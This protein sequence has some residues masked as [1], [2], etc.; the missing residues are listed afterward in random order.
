MYV[1]CK[2]M[3][4]REARISTTSPRAMVWRA[5]ALHG[6]CLGSNRCHRERAMCAELL[7]RS[8]MRRV[9]S[10]SFS[11]SKKS[12]LA[13]ACA[14]AVLVP[15]ASAEAQRGRDD[16]RPDN[17]TDWEPLGSAQIGTRLERDVIEVG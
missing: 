7:L 10:R 3:P 17:R 5:F 14:I 4:S 13:I 8:T 11:M 9:S 16:W 6:H 15:L 2:W 1:S 12:F